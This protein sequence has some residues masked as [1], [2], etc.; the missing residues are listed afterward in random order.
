MSLA[1]REEARDIDNVLLATNVAGFTAH[2]MLAERAV[3]RERG[4]VHTEFAQLL[5]ETVRKQPDELYGN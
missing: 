2:S 4:T 5:L 1:L 3:E